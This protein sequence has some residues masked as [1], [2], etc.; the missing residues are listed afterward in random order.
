MVNIFTVVLTLT[1]A[2]AAVSYQGLEQF[3]EADFYDG[4]TDVCFLQM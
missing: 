3:F 2:A 4:E 1:R